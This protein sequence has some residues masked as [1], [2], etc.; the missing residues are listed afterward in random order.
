MKIYNLKKQVNYL[1]KN[2]LINFINKLVLN[3]KKK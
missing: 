1:Y 2:N 3:L